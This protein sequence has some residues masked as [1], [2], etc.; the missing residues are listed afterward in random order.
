M[1]SGGVPYRAVGQ[2][3][4]F[5][6]LGAVV[7]LNGV[8]L[9]RLALGVASGEPSRVLLT[10]SLPRTTWR[11]DCGLATA[12]DPPRPKRRPTVPRRSPKTKPMSPYEEPVCC[13]MLRK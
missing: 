4:G 8:V 13:D 7:L 1:G 3:R 9:W 12:N 6:P 11:G 10:L 2:A 5:G